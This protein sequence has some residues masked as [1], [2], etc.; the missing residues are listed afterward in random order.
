L[1]LLAEKEQK[2][3]SLNELYTTQNKDIVILQRKLE[4]IASSIEIA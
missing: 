1:D 2:W 4:N 3:H